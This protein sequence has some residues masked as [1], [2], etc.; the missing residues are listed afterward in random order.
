M[1]NLPQKHPTVWAAGSTKSIVTKW[2]WNTTAFDYN[3][4]F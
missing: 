4:I 1:P 3:N 2:T